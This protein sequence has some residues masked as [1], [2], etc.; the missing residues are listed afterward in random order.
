[1]AVTKIHPIKSILKKAL[2]YITDLQKTDVKK[3][4]PRFDRYKSAKIGKN[5]VIRNMYKLDT[6]YYNG[7]KL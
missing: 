7:V 6:V 3:L 2:D 1:M 5:K 4:P